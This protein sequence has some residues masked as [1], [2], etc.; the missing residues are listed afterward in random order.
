M[1][2]PCPYS[3]KRHKDRENFD[4]R[5]RMGP[6]ISNDYTNDSTNRDSELI[7]STN[8]EVRR[9]E[10]GTKDES[11]KMKGKRILTLQA[12]CFGIK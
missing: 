4:R 8:D 9:S 2:I 6:E 3:K 1:K 7:D 11:Q 12:S 5:E 10:Y